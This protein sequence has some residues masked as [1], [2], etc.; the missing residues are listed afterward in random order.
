MYKKMLIGL[1]IIVAFGITA[2]YIDDVI[3]PSLFV[4][5]NVT[6]NS[7]LDEKSVNA[8]E[9][10]RLNATLNFMHYAAFL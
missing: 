5:Q 4:K 3:N 2:A 9:F 6:G 10:M 8:R 7:V 1:G